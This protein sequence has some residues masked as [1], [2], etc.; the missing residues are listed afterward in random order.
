MFNLKSVIFV[1]SI[2]AASI[3]SADI[4]IT[5]G[6]GNFPGDENILFNDPN[7][8][9]DGPLVRGISNQTQFLFN[10]FDA[11]ED[12]HVNGGQALVEPFSGDGYQA[13]SLEFDQDDVA[14]LTYI[15]NINVFDDAGDGTVHMYATPYGGSEVDLGVFDIG[16]TGENWFRFSTTNGD[17]IRQIRFTTDVDVQDIRQNRVGGVQVV[18][19][20]AS[21]A[22]IAMGLGIIAN[23]KRRKS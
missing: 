19:E 7:L 8:T 2:A 11:G 14:F 5:P 23:R 22:A 12:L 20:P 1:F 21:L 18:P 15:M 10:Y 4:I 6:P 3:A 9:N 16:A 13:L 17:M